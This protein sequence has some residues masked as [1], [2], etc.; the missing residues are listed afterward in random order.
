[1]LHLLL[2][3]SVHAGAILM[4][5]LRSE[6]VPALFKGCL[7]RM[8]WTAPQV[9][10]QADRQHGAVLRLFV[11][12]FRFS[13][14]QSVMAWFWWPRR[15]KAVLNGMQECYGCPLSIHIGLNCSCPV[16]G[17]TLNRMIVLLTL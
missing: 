10:S 15:Q 1:V 5:I 3:Q 6:G 8:A 13:F 7:F 11:S 17:A 16:P 12:S 9:S 2:L 14:L 4:G